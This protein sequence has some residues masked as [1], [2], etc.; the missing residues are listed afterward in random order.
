VD[1]NDQ[2]M[3]EA[4]QLQQGLTVL[5]S[6]AQEEYQEDLDSILADPTRTQDERL[7]RIGRLV[8]VVLKQP[9]AS[10]VPIVDRTDPTATVTGASRMWV[11]KSEAEFDKKTW[12]YEVLEALR[13]EEDWHPTVYD[14]AYNLDEEKRFFR[15]LVNSTRKYICGDPALRQ[16]IDAEV[17]A[18][19][20]SGG[21][22]SV[23]AIMGPAS[24]AVAVTLVQYVP[25][26]GVAGASL[27]AGLVLWLVLLI[28]RIGIDAFCQ[29]AESKVLFVE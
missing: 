4:K 19:L 7:L 23:A 8:G 21:A 13:E 15:F 28:K 5:E 20:P 24:T 25:W 9:F 1:T 6:L 27:I 10:P 12:Q 29:Y 17:K 16:K 18:S 22:V 26:L 3:I 14:L 11:L 2:N